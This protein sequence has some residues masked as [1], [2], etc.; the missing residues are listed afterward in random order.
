[1]APRTEGRTGWQRQPDLGKQTSRS[2]ATN[3]NMA[4]KHMTQQKNITTEGGKKEK[5]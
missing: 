5:E 3:A 1:M 4:S 2:L